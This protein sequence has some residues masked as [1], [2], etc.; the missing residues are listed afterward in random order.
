[1][2]NWDGRSRPT[3]SKYRENYDNIFKKRSV[4]V[5][6]HQLVDVMDGTD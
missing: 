3:N 6:D 4:L 5:V 1:M 2:A